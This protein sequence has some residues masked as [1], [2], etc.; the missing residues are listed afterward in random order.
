MEHVS[1]GELYKLVKDKGGLTECE[2]RHFFSQ[3]TDAVEYCHGKYIIHRDLKPSN[4]LLAD[5][6]AKQIKVLFLMQYLTDY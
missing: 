2:A 5:S 6:T 3:L 4:I 1:G